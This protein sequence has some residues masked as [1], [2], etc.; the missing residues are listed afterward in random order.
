MQHALTLVPGSLTRRVDAAAAARCGI[1]LRAARSVDD[2]SRRMLAG[3]SDAGEMSLATFVQAHAAGAALVA[4]P[5]VTGARFLEP[6][7]GVRPGAGIVKPTDIAGRRV[8]IPQYWMT[9]SVWHRAI[10]ERIHGVSPTAIEW[11]TVQPERIEGRRLPCN[12]SV[13]PQLGSELAELLR[14]GDI[15]AVLYPRPISDFFDGSIAAPLFPNRIEAQK[16]FF[17][18]CGF[19]P[20]MHLL[21][22]RKNVLMAC[23]QF[24]SDIEALLHGAKA[25]LVLHGGAEAAELPLHGAGLSENRSM[26]G[27]DLWPF[28]LKAYQPALMWFLES[29]V[30]QGLIS[31]GLSIES[32]FV[33][34]SDC[35]LA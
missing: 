29:A 18:A 17:M 4:L 13:S 22:I 16:L 9:S 2:S 11:V 3:E 30:Q 5:I 1:V 27:T 6:G 10:L 28:A 8:G 31:S 21:V 35:R 20:I 24:V 23:P 26:L 12:I 15:D 25:T 33:D 7:V 34:G 19:V 14:V 32:L